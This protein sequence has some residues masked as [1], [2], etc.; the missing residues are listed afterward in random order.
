MN[1]PQYS[2][3]RSWT[4]RIAHFFHS[5]VYKKYIAGLLILAILLSQTI[6][7]D[8]FGRAYAG[9]EGYRDIISIIVDTNTFARQRQ[10]IQT[11]AENI[12]AHF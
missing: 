11:Y 10:K 4:A 7:I 12:Q 5:F 1:L 8:F 6:R 2:Q 3:Q 9:V